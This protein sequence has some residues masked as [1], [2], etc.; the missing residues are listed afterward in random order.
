MQVHSIISNTISE[1]ILQTGHLSIRFMADGFSLLL[2]DKNYNPVV[3]N[4]FTDEALPTKINIVA[5]CEDWLNR[6]TLI[7][8]FYGEITI[9]SDTLA[10][11][12]IPSELFSEESTGLYLENITTLHPGNAV[13]FK[14]IKS[15]PYVLVYAFSEIV[16]ELKNKFKGVCRVYPVA[17]VLL[18]VADQVNASDHQRGF[19]IIEVQ[20][21]SLTILLIKNDELELVNQLKLKNTE[22]VVY[23]SLNT[24]HQLNFK[25]D[26][27]PVFLTGSIYK[28]ELSTLEKYIQHIS[29]LNYIQKGIDKEAITEHIVLAEA[30]K[31]E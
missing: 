4:R 8:D 20:N 5:A 26:T 11:T 12:F 22:E 23:H 27:S 18:S 15:R 28:D 2:E 31:C 21:D 9:V 1:E 24:L 16:N 25:R 17:H 7:D 13:A 14:E 3:L 29:P 30:S 19:A 10:S 6:H